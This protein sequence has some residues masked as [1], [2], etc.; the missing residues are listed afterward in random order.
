MIEA[1]TLRYPAAIGF[2]SRPIELRIRETPSRPLLRTSRTAARYRGIVHVPPRSAPTVGSPEADRAAHAD[3]G[4]TRGLPP[5]ALP[6]RR[7]SRRSG[8]E[9]RA[10]QRR[11]TGSAVC[12]VIVM[13][14]RVPVEGRRR[15]CAPFTTGSAT[16]GVGRRYLL[17][18]ASPLRP[19][20]P[21]QKPAAHRPL[22]A[23]ARKIEGRGCVERP[24]RQRPVCRY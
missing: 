10:G 17:L 18:L 4:H 5:S 24:C 6:R 22:T 16:K 20:L 9:R 2:P 23:A 7:G 19:R 8:G 11:P 12:T 14:S 21:P 1:P 3:H 15:C 13:S